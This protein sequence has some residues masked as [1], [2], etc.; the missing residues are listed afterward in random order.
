MVGNERIGSN[1]RLF[2]RMR[3]LVGNREWARTL[4]HHYRRPTSFA[5]YRSLRAQLDGKNGLEVG[6]PSAIFGPHGGVPLYPFLASWDNVDFAPR[7]LWS[8]P[9]RGG[10]GRIFNGSDWGRQFVAEAFRLDSI[11]SESYGALLNS[12]VIEHLANP[13][14]ALREWNRVLRTGGRIV[15]VVPEGS[16]TFDHAREPTTL[17]HLE[18][19]FRDEVQEDDLRHVPEVLRAHDIAMDPGVGDWESLAL[20]SRRNAEVRALHHHVFT[21]ESLPALLERAGFTVEAVARV[22]P[23]HMLAWG[24]KP[25]P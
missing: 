23:H 24:N 17:A 11:D 4:S 13:L 25:P 15:T 5:W 6:G 22:S 8:P 2:L 3:P 16:R 20:R 1:L 14:R 19:D 12:H 21:I 10:D 9:P 7:T 18:E